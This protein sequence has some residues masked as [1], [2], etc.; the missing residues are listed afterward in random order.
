MDM[1]ILLGTID[2]SPAG[3]NSKLL[4]GDLNGDGRMEILAVQA[5]GGIDDRY[6][7][8]Q[9]EAMT[10]F[11][12]DGTVLWQIGVPTEDP[13][14]FGSDFPAQIYDIDGDGFHE[15]LCVMDKKFKVIDGR[16]GTVKREWDLPDDEAH[17]CIIIANLRGKDRPEDIILKNRYEKM[18][19][20]DNEF[21]LL[22]SYEGNLGH[23]PWVYDFNGDGHDE[24]MAGYDMLDHKGNLLWSC[25]DLED[26]ADC[27]WVGDVDGDP[28]NGVE[29]VIGGSVT[30]M[31]RWNGEEI[32]R[33]EG[34]IESQHIALG[35]FREDIPGIQV[36]G[37]DRI[38]R[39]NENGKD[40]LFLLDAKGNEIWKENRTTKGWLTIIE[41]LHNWNGEGKDHILA[42]RRG[43]GVY[44]A[45]YDGYMNIVVQFPVDG[46][47]IH[48]DLLGRGVEDVIVY[49]N[50]LASIFS[51]REG[52]VRTGM[53]DRIL[54]QNKRLYHSTL[55][56]GGE[57]E[58]RIYSAYK[59]QQDLIPKVNQLEYEM[60]LPSGNY[61]IM[62]TFGSDEED[63]H[64]EVLQVQGRRLMLKDIQTNKGEYIK[65]DFTVNV[66]EGLLNI[67]AKGLSP[68]VKNIKVIKVEDV[69]TIYLAG[70]STVC[71]QE[72]APWAG[73]GQCLPVFLKRGIAVANHAYSGRSTKSFI[74][75][76]RLQVILDSLV[77]GDYLFIQFGHN[78]QKLGTFHGDP[79]TTYKENLMVYINETRKRGANPILVTP[80]HRRNFDEKGKIVNT[81][82]DYPDAIRQL[83][84]EENIPL[85]DLHQRSE[86]L[87]NQLGP[88][89]TKSIFVHVHPDQYV[90]YPDGI[91]D[92]THFS[93][94]GAYEIAKLVIEEIKKTHGEL[95]N[96]LR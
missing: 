32:W 70:D 86:S 89:V 92:N 72:E 75:E 64:V 6:V 45:L 54:P 55:Y 12:L 18:W 73:W 28:A 87:F 38:R 76:K 21:N 79:F 56:P 95:V 59:P 83:A 53:K 50:Q 17:D 27:I 63:S 82:G 90:Q 77:P 60:D 91:E 20:L 37:L 44:P 31:Y 25:K 11:D 29:V 16:Y 81:L 78:D 34:S 23:Y 88:E 1:P 48:G 65:Y 22:W 13:G 7:P 15:V 96:Y 69:P 84:K 33:Y 93:E 2:L 8:H 57:L 35:K 42:Y 58:P 71:D 43:G 66:K 24:V 68:A 5:N 85:L 30:V 36:A 14:G 74:M 46:Y 49:T 9:V 94:I 67:I 10:A 62:I 19:A 3:S 80:V 61:D 41:T 26:H 51:S 52:D 40:G 4:L 47:V 39:G